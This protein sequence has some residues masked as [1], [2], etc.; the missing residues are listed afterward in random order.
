MA[1]NDFKGLVTFLV[2]MVALSGLVLLHL[3]LGL[4]RLREHRILRASVLA[5]FSA[6]VLCMCLIALAPQLAERLWGAIGLTLFYPWVVVLLL[7]WHEDDTRR[8]ASEQAQRAQL[9]A[10]MYEQRLATL[11]QFRSFAMAIRADP[12]SVPPE[13]ATELRRLIVVDRELGRLVKALIEALGRADGAGE[14]DAI[15]VQILDRVGVLA[16]AVAE[17]LTSVQSRSSADP[18]SPAGGG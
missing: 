9:L 13:L 8:R 17:Q 3:R 16:P 6:T 18:R 5:S 15:A 11:D 4:P 12:K 14:M 2:A 1:A 10:R 7:G